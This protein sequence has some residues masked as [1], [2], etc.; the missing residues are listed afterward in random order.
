MLGLGYLGFVEDNI[1]SMS[2]YNFS[3]FQS[4]AEPKLEPWKQVR[5]GT[6]GADHPVAR[7]AEWESTRRTQSPARLT[8]HLPAL[9]GAPARHTPAHSVTCPVH[10][11]P[12]SGP[13]PAS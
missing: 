7:H 5:T 11:V 2:P 9:P 10:P 4:S 12:L 1:Y 3:P 13:C 8:N 6:A